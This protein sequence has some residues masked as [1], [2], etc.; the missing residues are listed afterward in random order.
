VRPRSAL[1]LR[2]LLRHQAREAGERSP[3]LPCRASHAVRE[4]PTMTTKK[5]GAQSPDQAAPQAISTADS[6][7]PETPRAL[8][9]PLTWRPEKPARFRGKGKRRTRADAIARKRGEYGHAH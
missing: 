7:A 1:P 2:L 6:T 5:E 3:R 4:P 9:N 8:Y